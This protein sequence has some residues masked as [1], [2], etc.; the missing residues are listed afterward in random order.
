MTYT[1]VKHDCATTQFPLLPFFVTHTK[2][3]GVHS[4]I[5]HF[6]IHLERKLGHDKRFG[7]RGRIGEAG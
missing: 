5:N 2:P 3:H 6:N 1:A 7:D 4:L